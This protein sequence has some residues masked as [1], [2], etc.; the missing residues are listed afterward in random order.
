MLLHLVCGHGNYAHVRVGTGRPK[1][2]GKGGEDCTETTLASTYEGGSKRTIFCRLF[3][4]CIETNRQ[5]A[6]LITS[7]WPPFLGYYKL[8][9][10]M[11]LMANGP[12]VECT[13][14]IDTYEDMLSDENVIAQVALPRAVANATHSKRMMGNR[15]AVGGGGGAQ[16]L[17][18]VAMAVFRRPIRM[19]ESPS[20]M[21]S[22][23]RHVAN[24]NDVQYRN[25]EVR[26]GCKEIAGFDDDVSS[27]YW[28]ELVLK[29]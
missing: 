10:A 28:S 29:T 22:R 19:Q 11:S 16:M 2:F 12:S 24:G 17:E 23:L 27:T 13:W 18:I 1:I 20:L 15:N 9:S 8:H 14:N 5:L 7:I 21:I 3:R 25:D 4:Q 6:W 26:K